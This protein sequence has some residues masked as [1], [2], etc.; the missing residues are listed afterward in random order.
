[1]KFDALYKQIFIAEADVENKV[2]QPED[3]EVEPAPLPTA[4]SDD[5]PAQ[6]GDTLSS[7]PVT[8]GGTISDYV[9]KIAEFTKVLQDEDGGDCLNQLIK[10]LDRPATPYTGIDGKVSADLVRVVEGLKSIQT[11]LLNY[12]FAAKAG[13]TNA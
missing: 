5:V 4:S 6:E 3:V 1:M 11:N 12:T 8:G 7:A 9:I 10:R 2:A 13:S